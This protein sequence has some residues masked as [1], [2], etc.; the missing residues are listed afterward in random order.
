MKTASIDDYL[1]YNGI[2]VQV[3]GIAEGKTIILEPVLET[4]KQCEHCGGKKRIHI[5][6]NC[7][8]F[9]N[10]AKPINTIKE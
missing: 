9:Q 8:N 1:I 2:L 3:V 7:P 10:M 5:L 4:D 6:E